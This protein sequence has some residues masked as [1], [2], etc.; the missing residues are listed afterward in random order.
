MPNTVWARTC[1][2]DLCRTV[3]CSSCCIYWVFAGLHALRV[4]WLHCIYTVHGSVLCEGGPDPYLQVQGSGISGP[5]LRVEP[6][7]DLSGPARI[8]LCSTRYTLLPHCRSAVANQPLPAANHNNNEKREPGRAYKA[9]LVFSFLFIRITTTP[10]T[11]REY[12]VYEK[13]AGKCH[14][15]LRG[16]GPGCQ[17]CTLRKP[18][19]VPRVDGF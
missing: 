16:T 14:R 17:V 3:Q 5:D 4:R 18:V 12:H 2:V 11:F 8:L 15:L 1:S 10:T 9:M 19:P 7:P 6:G 13:P